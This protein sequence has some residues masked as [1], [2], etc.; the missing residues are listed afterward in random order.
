M[1]RPNLR[2]IPDSPRRRGGI[3]KYIIVAAILGS[4]FRLAVPSIS[5][6]SAAGNIGVI[7]G[8]SMF[9]GSG[10]IGEVGGGHSF[11]GGGGVT[12]LQKKDATPLIRA[13]IADDERIVKKLLIREIPIN[14]YDNDGRT[15]I[16]GA[17][18]HEQNAMCA[19]LIAKGADPYIQDKKGFNAFD[20]AAARGLVKTVKLLLRDTDSPDKK[21]YIQF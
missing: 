3:L 6:F 17:A 11:S 7:G 1:R 10:G 16:I 8:G 9:G 15:A 4:I 5:L 14:G 18:Y 19:L 12:T 2:S 21:Y 20:F 13:A